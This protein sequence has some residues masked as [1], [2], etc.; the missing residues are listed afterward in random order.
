M[1]KAKEFLGKSLAVTKTPALEHRGPRFTLAR[2]LLEKGEKKSVLEYF[3]QVEKIWTGEGAQD[4]LNKMRSEVKA[5]KIP[6]MK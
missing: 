4:E 6:K 1:R 2:E 5:G 3:D